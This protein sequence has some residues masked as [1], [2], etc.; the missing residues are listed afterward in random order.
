MEEEALSPEGK[1]PLKAGK[2]GEMIFP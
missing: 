1:R 2:G